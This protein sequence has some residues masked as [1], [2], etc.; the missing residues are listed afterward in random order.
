MD[1]QAFRKLIEQEPVV[2]KC[3]ISPYT[4]DFLLGRAYVAQRTTDIP[5]IL[6]GGE[7]PRSVVEVVVNELIAEEERAQIF[8]SAYCLG[9]RLPLQSEDQKTRSVL[10]YLSEF[11]GADDPQDKVKAIKA[12]IKKW[13]GF[14]FEDYRKVEGSIATKVLC[15]LYRF[16]TNIYPRLSSLLKS[17][18]HGGK[19]SF[20]FRDAYPLKVDGR[21]SEFAKRNVTYIADLKANMTFEMG[22]EYDELRETLDLLLTFHEAREFVPLNLVAEGRQPDKQSRIRVI[23]CELLPVG[24][25]K[26]P[27]RLDVELFLTLTLLQLEHRLIATDAMVELLRSPQAEIPLSSV[28]EPNASYFC[29]P[30]KY[31]YHCVWDSVMQISGITL[32]NPSFAEAWKLSDIVCVLSGSVPRDFMFIERVAAILCVLGQ[33]IRHLR[34]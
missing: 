34:L 32:D 33:G 9:S 7:Y 12:D 17:P 3:G 5:R 8:P 30:P 20:E 10:N 22:S 15:A 21:S 13:T 16:R 24:S 31:T 1:V 11:P 23:I 28:P 2:Q 25:D 6:G 29:L 14:G 26:R 4:H 27:A 19:A 18:R